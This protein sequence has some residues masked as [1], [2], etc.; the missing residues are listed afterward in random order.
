M[1]CYRERDRL[2]TATVA[3]LKSAYKLLVEPKHDV[4]RLQ[5]ELDAVDSIKDPDLQLKECIRIRSAAVRL[6][7][8]YANRV[9]ELDIKMGQIINEFEELYGE[10]IP[11][12]AK[13]RRKAIN[14]II[15][16]M[17]AKAENIQSI[18]ETIVRLLKKQNPSKEEWEKYGPALETVYDKDFLKLLY[19]HPP[20]PGEWDYDESIKKA[21]RLIPKRRELSAEI[22]KHVI[23]AK[24]S[25]V[26]VS[27]FCR[28]TW[29]D[30]KAIKA[31][32]QAEWR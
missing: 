10:E 13:Q 25:D 5:R 1:R 6:G 26:P 7:Q 32:L 24:D 2:K 21:K 31:L 4:N 30:F 3:D 27:K 15:Q 17:L 14:G 11:R 22:L 16:K 12:T 19:D 23:T 8:E 18:Q 28:D 20:A 29:A 9:L